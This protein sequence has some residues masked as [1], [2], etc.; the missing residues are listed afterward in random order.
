MGRSLPPAVRSGRECSNWALAACQAGGRC[1]RAPSFGQ[2][3]ADRGSGQ[4]TTCAC[5]RP[6]TP[7]TDGKVGGCGARCILSRTPERKERM[8]TVRQ[9]PGRPPSVSPLPRLLL[10]R[11][12]PARETHIRLYLSPCG[13]HR[14]V[15]PPSLPFASQL[16]IGHAACPHDPAAICTLQLAP[17]PECHSLHHWAASTAAAALAPSNARQRL[18][19][20]TAA[21]P[22]RSSYMREGAP[23][24]PESDAVA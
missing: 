17:R 7:G 12:I 24:P 9:P 11:P 18:S 20:S 8:R 15:L 13:S 2:A 4:S 5:G 21:Q 16:P 14:G 1:G 22:I 3:R 6:S 10:A 19:R 23:P